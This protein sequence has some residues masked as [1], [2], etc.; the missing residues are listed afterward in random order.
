MQQ[1]RYYEYMKRRFRE[2]NAKMDAALQN[3][4]RSKRSNAKS[5]IQ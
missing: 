3:A 1:E 2:E 4:K 5:N